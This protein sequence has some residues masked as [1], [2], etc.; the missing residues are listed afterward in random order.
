MTPVKTEQPSAP[1][2]PQAK[3]QVAPR[4]HPSPTG[5]GQR[6]DRAFRPEAA[7]T[8][9][10]HGDSRE[11]RTNVAITVSGL[12]VIPSPANRQ[13]PT[14]NHQITVPYSTACNPQ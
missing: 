14:A 13:P 5:R 9:V 8:P 2:D 1:P 12:T 10:Q 4:P 11:Y 3:R 7:P 6:R